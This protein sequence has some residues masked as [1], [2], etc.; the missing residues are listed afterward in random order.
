MGN[1]DLKF[2]KVFKV[3]Y[4]RHTER[5]RDIG[6]WLSRLLNVGLD[7]MTPGSQPQPKA[8]AQLLSHPEFP[9]FQFLNTLSFRHL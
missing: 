3:I 4:E 8:D 2:F 7:P 9:R 5:G 1:G 6:K